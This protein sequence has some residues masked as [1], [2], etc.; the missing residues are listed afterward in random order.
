MELVGP[1]GI[2]P[3]CREDGGARDPLPGDRGPD[4]QTTG[5]TRQLKCRNS[6]GTWVNR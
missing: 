1:A 6:F 5:S 2:R 3:P 4:A